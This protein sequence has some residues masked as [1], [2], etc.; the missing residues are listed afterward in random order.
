MKR[1]LL[2]A[3]FGALVLTA[4]ALLATPRAAPATA[5][6]DFVATDATEC[7]VLRAALLR[8]DRAALAAISAYIMAAAK[9]YGEA[10]TAMTGRKPG[11]P[12]NLVGA[13]LDGMAR[14]YCPL[15]PTLTIH[16]VVTQ[17]YSA[18]VAEIV[19]L[20]AFSAR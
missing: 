3:I 18:T 9:Q 8:N 14:T 10:Y 12:L 19:A 6:P 11:A 17:T 5:M 1:H 16:R 13:A 20:R 2:G 7:T 15:F 4:P